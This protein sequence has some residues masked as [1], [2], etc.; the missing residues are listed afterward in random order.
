M[1]LFFKSLELD[2]IKILGLNEVFSQNE[3]KKKRKRI[4]VLN[5]MPLK[6]ETEAHILNMLYKCGEDLDIDF[7]RLESHKSKHTSEEY[8][9]KNYRTFNEVKKEL[10]GIIITGAPLEKLDFSEVSYIKELTDIFDYLRKYE[11]RSLYI[12]WGAQVALNH[13]YGV[14]KVVLDKK[15]FGVFSHEILKKRDILIGIENGFKAPHSRHSTLN[16]EDVLN[17]KNLEVLA[18]NEIGEFSFLKGKTNDYYILGHLEYGKDVL[19]KEYLRDKAKGEFIEIPT[20]Y[21]QGNNESKD[22]IFSWEKTAERIYKNWIQGIAF[23]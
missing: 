16:K 1:S 10:D 9:E 18:E 15:V 23:N 5:L 13:F 8:L 12:C 3:C 2:G 6:G 22:I 19:K 4:G 17:N 7:I 20:N 21:F 14:R 11:K